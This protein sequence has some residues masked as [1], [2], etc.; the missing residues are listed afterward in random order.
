MK[1]VG[2]LVFTFLCLAVRGGA[3]Q[4]AGPRNSWVCDRS[5]DKSATLYLHLRASVSV[6]QDEHDKTCFFSVDGA[7]AYGGDH[8]KSEMIMESWHRQGSTDFSAFLFKQDFP[9]T[10]L[11]YLLASAGPNGDG[12]PP[13]ALT[14]ALTS[15]DSMLHDCFSRFFQDGVDVPALRSASVL[16]QSAESEHATLLV[17]VRYVDRGI[18]LVNSLYIPR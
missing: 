3:Q 5:V 10:T 7:T 18:P 14:R 8:S 17:Q 16:C 6:L 11:P 9:Q 13:E 15:A 4:V 2:L 12:K 1:L